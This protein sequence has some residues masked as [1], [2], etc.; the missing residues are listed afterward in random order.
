MLDGVIDGYLQE[1]T[2]REFDMPLM[3]LLSSQG[4]L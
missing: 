4:F 3:A 1:V 2:E